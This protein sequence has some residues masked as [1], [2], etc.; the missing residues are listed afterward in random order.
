MLALDEL[1]V[2]FDA[3]VLVEDEDLQAGACYLAAAGGDHFPVE[4]DNVVEAVCVVTRLEGELP[5]RDEFLIGA[6][7]PHFEF[8]VP[9]GFER[10]GCFEGNPA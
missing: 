1:I 5:G 7:H 8:V 2:G 10:G 6:G 3:A 4:F 9:V